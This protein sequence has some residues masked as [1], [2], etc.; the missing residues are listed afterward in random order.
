MTC[1]AHTSF[2]VCKVYSMCALVNR[3]YITPK[4]VSPGTNG[5]HY[6]DAVYL[7]LP[8]LQKGTP[9]LSMVYRRSR[10]FHTGWL[11]IAYCKR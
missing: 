7:V 2:N 6:H 1:G 5:G 11:V 9:L 4:G 8:C 3:C 10:V